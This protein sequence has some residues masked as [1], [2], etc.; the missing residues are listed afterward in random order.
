MKRYNEVEANTSTQLIFSKP[1]RGVRRIIIEVEQ[2]LNVTID[3]EIEQGGTFPGSFPA[4]MFVPGGLVFD[5][6][7]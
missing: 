5:V 3:V 1:G 4:R 2:P 7:D 6:V